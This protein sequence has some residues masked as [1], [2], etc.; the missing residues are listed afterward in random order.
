[1]T[2]DDAVLMNTS[3]LV[4]AGTERSPT[5]QSKLVNQY[6]LPML[7]D[8]I[9]F[10][11]LEGIQAAGIVGAGAWQARGFRMFRSRI[12]MIIGQRWLTRDFIPGD[13][14]A[15]RPDGDGEIVIKLAEPLYLGAN[16]VI[17]PTV[18]APATQDVTVQFT[19]VGRLTNPRPRG[20]LL[21]LPYWT[22]Y[23]TPT[24]SAG[25]AGAFKSTRA[26]VSNQFKVPLQVKRFVGVGDIY[27]GGVFPFGAIKLRISD[28]E[29]NMLVRDPTD[30][31]ELFQRRDRAW[32]VSTVLPPGGYYIF[33]SVI[34]ATS[35][36]TP[37]SFRVSMFGYHEETVL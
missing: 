13:L 20:A 30:V 9:R 16:D 8:E 2:T 5:D 14:F 7:V 25:A 33:D 17:H 37:T 1:M 35:F 26:Q 6:R 31:L 18:R 15:P 23:T 21:K 28:H 22:S 10:A 27:P 34:D 11:S 4:P 36:L 24:V 32:A 19:L 29:G 3:W 12:N